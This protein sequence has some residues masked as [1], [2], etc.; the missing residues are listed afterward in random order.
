MKDNKAYKFRIYPNTLQQELFS[1]TFGAA[2]FVYNKM[3]EDKIAYYEETGKMLIN[4][5]KN[6]Y[7]ED[8]YFVNGD[9]Q[10]NAGVVKVGA[11][12]YY[13]DKDGCIVKDSTVEVVKTNGRIPEG[14]YK[15]R[16]G[17]IILDGVLKVDGKT[18]YFK[19][20]KIGYKAGLVEYKGDYYYIVNAGEISKGFVTVHSTNGLKACGVYEFD[21]EGKMITDKNGFVEENGSTYYYVNGKRTYAGLVE[22]DGDLYYVAGDCKPIKGGSYYIT[23]TNGL[24]EKSCHAVFDEDGKLVRFGKK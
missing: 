10:K 20:N 11:Y 3:L 15:T 7:G 22:V 18:T 6:V 13:V 23:H 12:F 1:K 2:R 21:A 14:T 19:N 8:K 9:L 16:N 4:G 5:I 24:I 17:I